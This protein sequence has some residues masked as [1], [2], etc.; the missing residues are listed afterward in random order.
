M[1]VD[2]IFWLI[3][4]NV[5]L[6]TCYLECFLEAI[7]EVIWD[8]FITFWLFYYDF[9]WFQE[10]FDWGQVD[11][12]ALAKCLLALCRQAKDLLKSESRLLRVKSPTYILGEWH[13][14]FKCHLDNKI[15]TIRVSFDIKIFLFPLYALIRDI[16]NWK[17]LNLVRCVKIEKNDLVYRKM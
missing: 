16:I 12:T 10:A 7:V 8:S 6:L 2:T 15:E 14:P 17:Y 4:V 9:E 13:F 11:R 3:L 5:W 1:H